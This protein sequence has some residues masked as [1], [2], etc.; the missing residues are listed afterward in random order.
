MSYINK[1]CHT[2]MSHFL[3][4]F[5]SFE[6][7][8]THAHTYTHSLSRMHRTNSNQEIL[9]CL[10]QM[11]SR[12]RKRGSERERKKR[13]NCYNLS[14]SFP[15]SHSQLVSQALV[16]SL[17]LPLSCQH[18]THL[19]TLSF[20]FSIAFVATSLFFSSL[21]DSLSLV[22][23]SLLSTPLSRQHN[24]Y[25]HIYIYTYMYILVNTSLLPK[26]VLSLVLSLVNTRCW[27]ES[28][29]CCRP[30]MD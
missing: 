29:W 7:E 8:N 30:R 12:K 19:R 1:S 25:I 5:F 26:R 11:Q 20:S 6:K 3:S 23:T 14:F 27:Q 4:F 2:W 16:S 21:S 28:V 24:I 15:L 9:H 17:S 10:Q 13:E 18:C 22:N